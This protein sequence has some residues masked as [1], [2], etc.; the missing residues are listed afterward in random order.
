M[1]RPD[2]SIR[3]NRTVQQRMLDLCAEITKYSTNEH[4]LGCA[5]SMK[6]LLTSKRARRMVGPRK[7]E[8]LVGS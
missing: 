3:M 1:P 8:S 7:T 4:V 2:E 5:A 6:V